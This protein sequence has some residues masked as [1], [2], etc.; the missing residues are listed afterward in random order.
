MFPICL[1]CSFVGQRQFFANPNP[2]KKFLL[3]GVPLDDNDPLFPPEWYATDLLTELAIGMLHNRTKRC[4]ARGRGMRPTEAVT[5][6]C[7]TDKA[8]APFFLFMSHFAPHISHSAPAEDIARFRG[9]YTEGWAKYAADRL[10]RQQASGLI[11]KS[12]QLKEAPYN[13]FDHKESRN[14]DFDQQMAVYAAMVHRIDIS[15]GTLVAELKATEKFENTLI[16]FLSDN[17]ANH[18]GL[19]AG[20]MVGDPTDHTSEWSAAKGWSY[21]Q[22]VPFRKFKGFTHEGGIATPLIAHWPAKITARAPNTWEGTPTHVIDLM[23]T[24]LEM[25]GSILSPSSPPMEGTSLLPLLLRTPSLP[26]GT[27][28]ALFWELQGRKAVRVGRM[29]LVSVRDRY[30]WD[31]QTEKSFLETPAQWELYDMVLDRTESTN[32]QREDEHA[33]TLASLTALW[34]SWAKCAGATENNPWIQR[35]AINSCTTQAIASLD[36]TL[37][38]RLQ[39][40]SLLDG[41]NCDL[42][43]L[44]NILVA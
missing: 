31:A 39:D 1:E 17:G 38:C 26:A 21:L 40:A 14:G 32:L 8:L 20:R 13:F 5:C 33:Q 43:N 6:I 19:H 25:S 16:L 36:P 41:K 30:G 27:P 12:W 9:S 10:A 28:R 3:D 29:K 18:K 7:T 34:D 44:Q 37:W 4:V 22:D 24:L 2:H 23:P 42:Q 11:A 15:V 35:E